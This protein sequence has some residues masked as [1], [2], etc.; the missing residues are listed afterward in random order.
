[1][2]TNEINLAFRRYL[3]PHDSINS[4]VSEVL[5]VLRKNF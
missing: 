1:M 2:M 3:K 5:F 4:K